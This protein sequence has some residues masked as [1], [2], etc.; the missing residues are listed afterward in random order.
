MKQTVWTLGSFLCLVGWLSS[1]SSNETKIKPQVKDITQAVYAS[2]KI[3]PVNY[4]KVNS[5]IPGYIE[6]IL[7]EVGDTIEKGQPL[8]RIKNETSE[9]AEK[10]AGNNLQLAESFAGK[11]SPLIRAAEAEVMAAEARYQLDSLN[12]QRQGALRKQGVGTELAFDQAKTSFK[13]SLQTLKK[14]REGLLQVKE[15]AK[16]DAQNAQT[17]VQIVREQKGDLIVRSAIKGKVYDILSKV[18]DYLL[19]QA[20]VMEIGAL[21]ALEVELAIDETDVTY[22]R[23]GQEVVFTAEGYDN[24]YF[25]GRVTKI[26]PKISNLNKSIK[27]IA[28]IDIPSDVRL[29]AAATLE[30]NIVYARKKQALVLPKYLVIRDSVWVKKGVGEEKVAVKTGVSDVEFVEILSGVSADDEIIAHK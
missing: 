26:Y 3:Y 13:N 6:T 24:K 30:A 7:V 5:Q 1:C 18:G 2:G 8:F 11:T 27:A 19:P 22:V 12:F 14:T 17:Q 20:V 25:T 4:Y 28:T 29:Y 16:T 9:L 15:K 21:N 23:S 10:M